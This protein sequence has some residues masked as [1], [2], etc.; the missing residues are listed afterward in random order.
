[1]PRHKLPPGPGRPKGSTNAVTADA[2]RAMEYAF[3]GAGGVEA[4]TAWAIANPDGFYPV[5]AKLLPKNVDVT[6]GGQ[7]L[8]SAED[9]QARILA[10]LEAAAARGKQG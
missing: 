5:W 4:L 8:L 1:M 6:S 10:I 3:A 9:R 2:K 7:P